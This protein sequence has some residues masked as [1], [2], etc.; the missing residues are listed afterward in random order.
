MWQRIRYGVR[1]KPQ[2]RLALAIRA[3]DMKSVKSVDISLDPLREGNHSVRKF[4]H[5]IMTPKVR[6]TN[7]SLKVSAQIRNDRHPPYFV[8]TLDNGKKLQFNTEN[9]PAMDLIMRFNKL[10]GNPEL[11]KSGTR[12][13]PKL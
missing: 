6:M 13:R 4:W 11:G 12:P 8:A 10:V 9:M 2:E 5:S 7:P 1:W 3:L